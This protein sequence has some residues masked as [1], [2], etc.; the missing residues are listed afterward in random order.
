MNQA[1]S[2]KQRINKGEFIIGVGV[3]MN[4]DR[5]Q[6]EAI[7]SKDTYGYVSVDSQHSAFNEDRL[8]QFCAVA[9]EA[10]IPAIL[11]IKHTRHT[12]LIGNLLDLGPAG[13]EVPQVETT[14]TVDEGIDYFYYPQV[15]R[16]SWGGVARWGV[17]GRED[18]LEYAAWWNSHG[19]LW[20]QIESINSVTHARQLAK[21]GVDCLSWGPADLSFSREANP[22]HP[23]KTDDD[24]VK[25]V[26]KVLEGSGTRLCVRSYDP[27]LRNKYRDMGVTVLLERPKP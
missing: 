7:L 17:K 23:L 11:R 12:Y 10:G 6:L 8:A 26:V 16:R 14:A 13:V 20:M 4:T 3:G 1:E 24:C 27:A 25:Y 21:K 2:L 5:K 19:V 22:H 15:G 9:S 18:R